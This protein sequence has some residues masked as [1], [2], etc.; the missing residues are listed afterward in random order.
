MMGENIGARGCKY[1]VGDPRDVHT[2]GIAIFCG[3][4]VTHKGGVWWAEH[5]RVVYTTIEKMREAR[6][7]PD[8]MP[9]RMQG[10]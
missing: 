6:L 1:I 3:K 2:Q 5:E 4:P 9:R 8:A 7:C 10:N